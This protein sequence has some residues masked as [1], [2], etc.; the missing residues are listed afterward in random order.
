MKFSRITNLD[1]LNSLQLTTPISHLMK[2]LMLIGDIKPE[3]IDSANIICTVDDVEVDC[4]TWGGTL[5]DN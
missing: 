2:R 1:F 5:N 3:T 4:D